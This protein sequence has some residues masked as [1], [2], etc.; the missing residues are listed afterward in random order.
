MGR[1]VR[2]KAGHEMH[3]GF[4]SLRPSDAY[5]CVS[6]VIIIC[7]DNVVWTVPSHYMNLCWN[8]ANGT[9]R[10]KFQLN[11]NWSLNNFPENAL[12]NV[13]CEMPSVFVVTTDFEKCLNL[14]VV[15]K[16]AWYFN[17]LENDFLWA[18]KLRVPEFCLCVFYAFCAS[19]LKQIMGFCNFVIKSLVTIDL[20]IHVFHS[21][22]WV[23][24]CTTA[25]CLN[26]IEI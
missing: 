14:N 20:A 6:N 12:K 23:I 8:I 11:F 24:D 16:S 21:A 10:N 3:H 25:K 5:I 18:W 13:V 7:S 26:T 15:L 4:N 17:L 9:L 2:G 19:N 22:L 1:Q